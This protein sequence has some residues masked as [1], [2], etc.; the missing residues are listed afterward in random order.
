MQFVVPLEHIDFAGRSHE[1]KLDVVASAIDL[2][3]FNQ[4]LHALDRSQHR[5]RA[6]VLLAPV[7]TATLGIGRWKAERQQLVP[8]RLSIRLRREQPCFPHQPVRH[9]I[10]PHVTLWADDECLLRVVAAV[11]RTRTHGSN[12]FEILTQPIVRL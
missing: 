9:F 11:E 8:D 12:V 4:L 7:E 1:L 10:A 6:E 5:V 2:R 3:L